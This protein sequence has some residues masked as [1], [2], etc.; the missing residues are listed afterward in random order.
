MHQGRGSI[1]QAPSVAIVQSCYIPWRGYF[2]LIG[3]VDLF[4]VYDDVQYSK[5]HW[6]NR[7]AIKTQHG[8]KW[9]TI[10]VSKAD[11]AFPRIDQV[12][13]ADPFAETHWASISQAYAKAPYFKQYAGCFESLFQRAS[14][15]ERLAEINILF[16]TEVSRILGLSTQFVQSSALGSTGK[17]TDRVLAICQELGARCYLSGPSAKGYFEGDKF[18]AAGIAYRWMDY[19]SYPPYPQL[20]GDFEGAVTILD[21]IFNV[22]PAARSYMKAPVPL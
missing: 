17:K 15:M 16:L 11:G 10:P 7:N 8:T 3:S 21:L 12:K 6:H 19:S 20:H 9:L 13:V 1:G 14:S 18:D 2:D 4:V 5:N 22:G